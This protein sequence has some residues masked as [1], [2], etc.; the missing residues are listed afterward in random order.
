[1]SHG[2]AHGETKR[3]EYE[4]QSVIRLHTHALCLPEKLVLEHR[5]RP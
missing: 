4:H 3:M 5:L 2:L 1:M